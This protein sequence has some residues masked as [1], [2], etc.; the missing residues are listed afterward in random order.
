M[1]QHTHTLGRTARRT[2]ILAI[3]LLVG[4]TGTAIAH[5]SGSYGGMMGSGWGLSGGLMGVWGLLWMGLLVAIPLFFIY[6]L[7]ERGSDG[8][9]ERS[10]S[11]LRE[12]YARGELTDDEF[13]RRRERLERSG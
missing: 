4:A 9:D 5:G 6:S 12:R 8:S 13:E 3:P 7:L 11:V 1:I 10:L 2:T